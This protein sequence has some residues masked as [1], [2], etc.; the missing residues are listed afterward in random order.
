MVFQ[1]GPSISTKRTLLTQSAHIERLRTL[2]KDDIVGYD[3]ILIPKGDA[4][5]NRWSIFAFKHVDTL[6][7]NSFGGL[8]ELVESRP[9]SES[10]VFLLPSGYST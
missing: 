3:G 7:V 1:T 4:T 10:C 9:H 6:V 5:N 2:H 8:V